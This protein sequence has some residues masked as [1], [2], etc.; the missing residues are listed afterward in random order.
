MRHARQL[1]KVF[2]SVLL[3]AAVAGCANTPKTNGTPWWTQGPGT[4]S[5]DVLHITEADVV[6]PVAHTDYVRSPSTH[7]K[8]GSNQA[9]RYGD[10][11]FVS[12]QIAVEPASH[13]IVGSDIQIQVRTAMDNVMRILAS[14]GMTASNILSVTMYM[15]DIDD[16]PAADSVYVSY[17]RGDLPA[18]SV[19]DVNGLAQGSRVEISVIAGK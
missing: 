18:R 6:R 1:S 14:H 11:L 19:V 4:A 2:C 12:G 15:Q 16:L 3:A 5:E 10:L 13:A 7:S 17:F 8:G 9:V